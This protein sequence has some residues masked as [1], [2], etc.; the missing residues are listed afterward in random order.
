MLHNGNNDMLGVCE[1]I[2]GVITAMVQG[3]NFSN[4][5]KVTVYL[6]SRIISSLKDVVWPNC[7]TVAF[8]YAQSVRQIKAYKIGFEY[9]KSDFYTTNLFGC[10]N[11]LFCN[12]EMLCL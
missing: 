12:I 11:H 3:V 5:F 9:W 8:N 1:G 10:P 7:I 6:Q 2:F 4:K